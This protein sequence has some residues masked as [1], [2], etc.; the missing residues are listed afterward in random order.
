M[1]RRR[2]LW[3]LLT[4]LAMQAHAIAADAERMYGDTNFRIVLPEGYLGPSE[5]ADGA[6]VSQIARRYRIGCAWT[7]PISSRSR[8]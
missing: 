3:T 6:S 5:H 8:Q 7:Y 2:F 4:C 1:R